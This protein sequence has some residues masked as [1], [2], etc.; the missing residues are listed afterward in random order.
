MYLFRFP[1]TH[2]HGENRAKVPVYTYIVC[3]GEET[4][5][6][7]LSLWQKKHGAP[8]RKKA[9]FFQIF[10]FF[11]SK[12]NTIFFPKKL[13]PEILSCGIFCPGVV[14]YLLW[15]RDFERPTESYSPL[16]RM[17]N[18]FL[19]RGK[20]RLFKVWNSLDTV[21][22]TD[23]KAMIS[24]KRAWLWANRYILR[25]PVNGF[26]RERYNVVLLFFAG[27]A[28]FCGFEGL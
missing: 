26:W 24:A 28:V 13:L 7:A 15:A 20:G 18:A 22:T 2:I 11:F 10:F 12:M 23:R 8:P 5:L 27:Q 21:F 9:I 1:H 4:N 19:Q 14:K 3:P 6:R 16:C 25:L 17:G